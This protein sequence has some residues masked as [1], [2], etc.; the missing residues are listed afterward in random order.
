VKNRSNK[1]SIM[2]QFGSRL[3][4]VAVMGLLL[5]ATG[6]WADEENIAIDKLPKA[7]TDAIKAKYPDAKLV[8]AEKETQGDK[9]FFEVVIKDK[10]RNI[11]LLLT[12]EGKIVGVEQP[13]AAKDLPKAVAEAIEKKYP[14]GTIKSVE[15]ATR[16]DKV[17]YGVLLE[18]EVM[19][20][21]EKQKVQLSLTA[22]GKITATQQLIGAK[23]L[24]RE[25]T[26]ALEKKYPKATITRANEATREGKVTYIVSLET[27]EKKIVAMLDAEGKIL[28]DF[29]QDKKEKK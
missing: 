27:T 6:A 11:E 15:E 23:D 26:G 19:I 20:D 13:I 1:E 9:T 28:K 25:V 3:S 16:D 10:D 5:A 4:G 2:V 24:P 17:T 21:K 7:V 12:P 8:G 22:D 29:S 14:K 18:T